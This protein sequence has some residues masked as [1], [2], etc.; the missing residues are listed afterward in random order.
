MKTLT[1]N[2][3]E[4]DFLRFGFKSEDVSFEEFVKKIKVELAKQALKDAQKVA[5]ETELSKM[6]LQDISAE[7]EAVRGAEN[8]H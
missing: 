2:I 8:S 1:I 4:K 6:S 3:A 5:A 7:I